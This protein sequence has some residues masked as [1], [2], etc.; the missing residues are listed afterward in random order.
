M[1]YDVAS[2]STAM[3]AIARRRRKIILDH[4]RRKRHGNLPGTPTVMQPPV[5][6]TIQ[7]DDYLTHGSS[8]IGGNLQSNGTPISAQCQPSHCSNVHAMARKGRRIILSNRRNGPH[9]P[10][11][12]NMPNLGDAVPSTSTTPTSCNRRPLTDNQSSHSNTAPSNRH[13][14]GVL[15]QK[16]TRLSRHAPNN[17]LKDFN[18]ADFQVRNT[19]VASTSNASANPLNVTRIVDTAAHGTTEAHSSS[20]DDI[21]LGENSDDDYDGVDNESFVDAYLEEYSD[22]GDRVW[23]CQFCHAYMWYQERKQKSQNTTVPK[24]HK[25][26]KSGKVVLPLLASPP[27]LLQHLLHSGTSSESKNYQS[28]LCTYNAMFSFTSPGMK[29]DKTVADGRGPPTLRLHGQTC[30]RIGTLIPE[31]RSTPQ[32]TQLYIFDTDNEVDNRIKCFSDSNVV[33]RGVVVKLKDM[34]DDCNPHAKA[35]RMARDLLKGNPFLD[36]KI[37]LIGDHPQDGRV[38][39]TPTVSEVA[40]LIVGD[41]DPDT[42]RDIII[43][44]RNGHLQ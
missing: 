3:A 23:E 39:N 20:E 28:N 24:F 38:Y 17:L 12:E 15:P 16:R 33:D 2:S 37:R 32:Y 6:G 41:I 27:P 13:V 8:S 5:S 34:L 18:Q 31:D 35:F 11:K 30:H 26:C 4:R 1:E 36:L 10:D 42:T 7:N 25:C 44:G 9:H 29:F 19:D 14:Q 43:H 22:I 21:N 40:A